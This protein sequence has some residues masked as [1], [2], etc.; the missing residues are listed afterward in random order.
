MMVFIYLLGTL[1]GMIPATGIML[2]AWMAWS[3]LSL[4]LRMPIFLLLLTPFAVVATTFSMGPQV[5]II[6][7]FSL[8]TFIVAALVADRTATFVG[9][10]GF[11]LV[12]IPAALAIFA[13]VSRRSDVEPDYAIAGNLV[14]IASWL[15]LLL[16]AP[17]L[18]GYRLM[19]LSPE[20]GDR[21]MESMTGKSIDDWIA[22]IDSA[23]G[24][25]WNFAE[26]MAYLLSQGLP[27]DA[28]KC[29][30][31]S[32]FKSKGLPLPLRSLDDRFKV[33]RRGTLMDWI[34]WASTGPSKR[35]QFSV[36]QLMMWTV[37]AS[38]LFAVLSK[39][40]RVEAMVQVAIIFVPASIAVAVAVLL[41]ADRCLSASRR[42]PRS[43][44]LLCAMLL[45]LM[46]CL[47]IDR[48]TIPTQISRFYGPLL[49]VSTMGF[50]WYWMFHLRREG[51][52]LVQQRQSSSDL[53]GS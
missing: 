8:F 33:G 44:S 26:T 35:D 27:Q 20:A 17:R 15:S 22:D 25:Q 34:D 28:C 29:V 14:F 41:M 23:D 12:V 19:R 18:L 13:I 2:T 45:W 37:S 49:A 4:L 48:V 36:R 6:C 40:A 30:A 31:T 51:F 5:A 7:S 50:L 43:L 3:P 52:R 11:F 53:L 24:G 38:V 42:M 39:V 1:V 16:A 47:W 9:G 10:L 21:S 32:I 46:A